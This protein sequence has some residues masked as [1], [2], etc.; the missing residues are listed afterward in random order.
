MNM[1]SMV[2][3][4]IGVSLMQ[5]VALAESRIYLGGGFGHSEL[6]EA[7][8]VESDVA[9]LYGGVTLSENL[10]FETEWI[11]L[12]DFDFDGFATGNDVESDTVNLSLVFSHPLSR[13]FSLMAKGGVHYTE[14]DIPGEDLEN[15]GFSL[16]LGA[17]Y[18]FDSGFGI[19]A[20]YQKLY[21]ATDLNDD[22]ELYSVGVHFSF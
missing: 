11:H 4:V 13:Q 19:R 16:G 1:K 7:T 9:K 12:D 20:E 15:S 10:D 18:D 14:I 3:A 2:V 22:F 8:N 5:S 21:N 17:R 6:N